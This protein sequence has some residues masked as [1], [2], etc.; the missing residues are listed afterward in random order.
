[1]SSKLKQANVVTTGKKGFLVV[2]Y[3]AEVLHSACNMHR[4]LC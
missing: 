1:M 2:V 3:P 4:A